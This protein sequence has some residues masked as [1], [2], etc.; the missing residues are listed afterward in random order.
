MGPVLKSD[1]KASENV[2][3]LKQITYVNKKNCYYNLQKIKTAIC[4]LSFKITIH[5]LWPFFFSLHHNQLFFRYLICFQPSRFCL[6]IVLYVNGSFHGHCVEMLVQV[7]RKDINRY[8]RCK[9]S[10]C[11]DFIPNISFYILLDHIDSHK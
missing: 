2:S 4:N 6:F 11:F 7:K 3:T 1:A 8:I 5:N 10:S 9:Y